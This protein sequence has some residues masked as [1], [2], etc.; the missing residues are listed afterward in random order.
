MERET[1]KILVVDDDNRFRATLEDALSALGY[2][3]QGAHDAEQAVDFLKSERFDL[4]LSDVKMP[5][6]GGIRLTQIAA[7]IH[8]DLPIV[9]ITGHGDEEMAKASL[10]KGASDFITKPLR[11]NELP[12]IVARNLERKRI[13]LRQLKERE[14]DVFFQAIQALAAAV[15]AKDPYT[16]RHSERVTKFALALAEILGLSPDEQYLLRLAATMHDVGKIGIPDS[17]LTKP[18]RLGSKEWEL[19]RQHPSIGARIV[20]RIEELHQVAEAIRHH[21]ERMD[22]QGYPDGLRNEAIPF[23]SRIIAVADSY[24]AMISDRVYRRGFGQMRALEE[25]KRSAGSQFD[26]DLVEV[27]VMVAEEAGPV[28]EAAGLTPGAKMC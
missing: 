6:M 25:L 5:G 28:H 14:G 19:I 22:G 1:V 8:P 3:I 13:T 20:G 27:F 4:L 21:H 15:D 26:P 18:A 11:L 24:D 17:V 9:L 2:G 12:I 7:E 16:A 10:Q 23:L